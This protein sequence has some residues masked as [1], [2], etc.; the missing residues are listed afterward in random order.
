MTIIINILTEKKNF[1][2]RVL[3]H[4]S[5]FLLF[6]PNIC[7]PYPPPVFKSYPIVTGFKYITSLKSYLAEVLSIDKYCVTRQIVCGSHK[8][9]PLSCLVRHRISFVTLLNLRRKHSITTSDSHR[10]ISYDALGFP[11][12]TSLREPKGDSIA[13]EQKSVKNSLLKRSITVS[14]IDKWLYRHLLQDDTIGEQQEY[15]TALRSRESSEE[16]TKYLDRIYVYNDR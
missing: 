13:W 11:I 12:H 16:K 2:F 8:S 5:P 9:D 3:K 7:M 14:W 6:R 1:L 15:I 4:F 10:R